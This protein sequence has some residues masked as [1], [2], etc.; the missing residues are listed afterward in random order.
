MNI[1]N[2]TEN[3]SGKEHSEDFSGTCT[4][5]SSAQ[6]TQTS[7]PGNVISLPSVSA[8]AVDVRPEVFKEAY[9]SIY[10][11]VEVLERRAIK[12]S[13]LEVRFAGIK[14]DYLH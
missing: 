12:S 9:P 5:E 13:D 7:Q 11:M 10:K 14:F 1:I 3:S 8:S 6:F 2:I 4:F